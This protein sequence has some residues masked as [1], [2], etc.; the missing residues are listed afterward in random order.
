MWKIIERLF[1][2]LTPFRSRR[3]RKK[4]DNPPFKEELPPV[5]LSV[6]DSLRQSPEEKIRKPSTEASIRRSFDRHLER[7][8]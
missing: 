7:H 3:R 2:S 6:F 1:S 5:D 8:K 4:N